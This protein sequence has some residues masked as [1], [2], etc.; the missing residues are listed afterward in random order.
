MKGRFVERCCACGIASRVGS[1]DRSINGTALRGC[2]YRPPS[3]A[4]G[5]VELE[6]PPQPGKREAAALGQGGSVSN[7]NAD[8]NDGDRHVFKYR[9]PLSRLC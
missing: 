3:E 5:Q 4:N 7:R 1:I 9:T 8:E 2:R 6:K